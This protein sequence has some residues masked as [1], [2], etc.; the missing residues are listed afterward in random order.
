MA[1]EIDRLCSNVWVS[2]GSGKTA[3]NFYASTDNGDAII[4]GVSETDEV[5]TDVA[6]LG[7]LRAG[8]LSLALAESGI[9]LDL[10]KNWTFWKAGDSKLALA[11]V[12]PTAIAE[13]VREALNER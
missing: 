2:V 11:L 12:D 6:R 10:S 4:I 3:Y 9:V 8:R 5:W 7:V 1:I 13:A